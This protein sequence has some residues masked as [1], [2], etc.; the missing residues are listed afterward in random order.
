MAETRPDGGILFP[1]QHPQ[2]NGLTVRDWFAGQAV[3]NTAVDLME[4]DEE[5]AIRVARHAYSIADAMLA[6]RQE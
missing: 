5:N 2:S 1:M 4:P 6:V 3:L